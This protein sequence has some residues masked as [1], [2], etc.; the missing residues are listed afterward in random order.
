M[1]DERGAAHTLDWGPTP[2]DGD[3]E[4]LH[5]E[6]KNKLETNSVWVMKCITSSQ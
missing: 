1:H 6:D 4:N 5:K 3:Y 2:T